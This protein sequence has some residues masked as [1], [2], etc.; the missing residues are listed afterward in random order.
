M[1]IERLI[2][3]RLIP[4]GTKKQMTL[5]QRI[6]Y[7][8]GLVVSTDTLRD[9]DLVSAFYH[10]L[11]CDPIYER[12]AWK[13]VQEYLEA[14]EKRDAELCNWILSEDFFEMMNEAAPI[15]YYFGVSEGD[16]ACFGFWK[17][18]EEED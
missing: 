8:G 7:G 18:E 15:G 5:K 16:G 6:R 12:K 11:S 3:N 10:A 14:V 13:L 9:E 4:I 2:G 17:S 1:E